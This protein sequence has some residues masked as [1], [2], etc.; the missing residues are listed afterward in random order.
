MTP[1]DLTAHLA[2]V[3][4]PESFAR[5]GL[6]DAMAAAALGL[7]AGLLIARIARFATVRKTR[8]AEAARAAIAGLSGAAPQ[9]RLAG[10][11]QLL[12]DHGGTPPDGLGQALYN[13]RRRF[14][15]APLEAAIIAAAKGPRQ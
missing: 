10:L 4:I 1:E 14:D 12:L 7:V 5:F 11:T 15:P 9:A 3:R 6:Q 2:D 13:P 8:P